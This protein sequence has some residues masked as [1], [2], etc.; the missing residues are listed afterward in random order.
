MSL[1]LPSAGAPRCPG[2]SRWLRLRPARSFLRS[3][4][5]SRPE[6]RSVNAAYRQ[7]SGP[8]ARTRLPTPQP[9]AQLRQKW[10]A[11]HGA[12]MRRAACAWRAH[13]RF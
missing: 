7:C 4:A 6:V 8:P 12:L 10:Y 3:F 11:M 9:G 5:P 1:T 13:R 2:F